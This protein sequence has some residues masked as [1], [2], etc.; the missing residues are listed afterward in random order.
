MEWITSPSFPFAGR[1]RRRSQSQAN[2]GPVK[3]P[4]L[5]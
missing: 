4:M 2:G 5:G 1:Q 3:L